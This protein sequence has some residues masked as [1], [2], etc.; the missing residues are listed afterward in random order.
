[1]ISTGAGSVSSGSGTDVLSALLDSSKEA[2]VVSELFGCS[3][4]GSDVSAQ[5]AVNVKMIAAA[6]IALR[7]FFTA[8]IVFCPPF[9]CL[10]F[11]ILSDSFSY[12]I[13]MRG[14]CQVFSE[15]IGTAFFVF[16]AFFTTK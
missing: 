14:S 6:V 2:E 9:L 5:H 16:I 11:G 4:D 8:A 12:Y 7:I 1:M 3:A 15:N 13:C 10:L